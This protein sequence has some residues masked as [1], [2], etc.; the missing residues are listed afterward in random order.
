MEGKPLSGGPNPV[1]QR[2]SFVD[3]IQHQQKQHQRTDIPEAQT[4][5]TGRSE[6]AVFWV[7][8]PLGVGGGVVR[9]T[10]DQIPDYDRQRNNPQKSV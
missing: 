6:I 10:V 2:G 8:G 1:Q 4:S 9:K 7:V 3:G 5:V